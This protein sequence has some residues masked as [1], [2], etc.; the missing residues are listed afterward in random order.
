MEIMKSKALDSVD[1]TETFKVF[2]LVVQDIFTAKL[3]HNTLSILTDYS[4]H[5]SLIYAQKHGLQSPSFTLLTLPP[6]NLCYYQLLFLLRIPSKSSYY[7]AGSTKT[8]MIKRNTKKIMF[9]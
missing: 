8:A 6:S 7:A 2:G 1:N 4:H 9:R 3:S 5:K